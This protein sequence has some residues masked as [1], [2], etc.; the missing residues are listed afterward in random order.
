M[1][2]LELYVDLPEGEDDPTN[3]L[4]RVLQDMRSAGRGRPD[5]LQSGNITLRNPDTFRPV[6]QLA[7][8]PESSI[9]SP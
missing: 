1:P 8:K 4:L 2:R 5:Q 7:V 6:G 3:F 9:G